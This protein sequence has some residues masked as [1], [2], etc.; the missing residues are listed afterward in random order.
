M[1]INLFNI[2]REHLR[3]KWFRVMLYIALAMFLSEY[4]APL[5]VGAAFIAAIR[6]AKESGHKLLSGSTIIPLVLYVIYMIIGLTYT[7]DPG[8]TFCN[9]LMWAFMLIV[10]ISF[11][12]VLTSRKRFR[13]ALIMFTCVTAVNGAV[14]AVQYVI[15]RFF[16]GTIDLQL[17]KW[18]ERL[19]VRVY[20]IELYPDLEGR[21]C[22][23]FNNA[24][25]FA[26]FMVML[27]PFVLCCLC[28]RC[29][30]RQR[31]V[32]ILFTICSFVG[33]LFTFSRGAY[34]ALIFILLLFVLFYIKKFPLIIAIAVIVVAVLPSTVTMR[35]STIGTSSEIVDDVSKVV[36][37]DE[38]EESH[39]DSL[40]DGIVTEIEK[41]LQSTAGDGSIIERFQVW[42][43]SLNLISERPVFGYG[44]GFYTV[45]TLLHAQNIAPPHAHNL[46]L[47]VMLE[48]GV[49]ALALMLWIILSSIAKG[50]LMLRKGA[51]PLL[52]LCAVAYGGAFIIVSLTDFPLLT[53][54][55]VMA[56]MAVL[57]MIDS[58]CGL[59]CE[60][61]TK[62]FFAALFPFGGNRG[63]T[64]QYFSS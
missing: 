46:Y 19:I 61:K 17:W 15:Y 1:L 5:L 40:L 2:F 62:S 12:T 64:F 16:G 50:V 44:A 26:E 56:F 21:S 25:V 27:I 33:V 7:S 59:Y 20:P 51:V 35:F 54:K 29:N 53:P 24:N 13:C 9:C 39:S 11:V 3:E 43:A 31:V 36:I 8:S 4:L 30:N 41:A 60:R 38:S 42:I 22:S 57:G 32:T 52:G 58:A 48:G 47:Q 6:E 55:L 49:I 37:D 23:T 28:L 14:A 34:L 45:Q 18:F 63:E 10:Y